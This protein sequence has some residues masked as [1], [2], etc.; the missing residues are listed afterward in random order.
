MFVQI[1]TFDGPRSAEMV[2]AST[3][4]GRDRIA[5]LIDADPD[6][7]ASLLGSIKAVAEDGG[8]CIVVLAQDASALDRLDHL[9]R[10]SELLPGED[11]ALLPGPSRIVRYESTEAFGRL[12]ELLAGVES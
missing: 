12:A 9:V 7:R 10:T 3:R 6:L 2:E 4:A 5:P 11:P 1:A 8:E